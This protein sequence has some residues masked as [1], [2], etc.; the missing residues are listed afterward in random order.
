M[1]ISTSN[2]FIYR[3]TSTSPKYKH[4]P[5][6]EGQK[7]KWKNSKSQFGG[8]ALVTEKLLRLPGRVDSKVTET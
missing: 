3:H 5:V 1:S 4:L 2:I 6:Q 7:S 8:K